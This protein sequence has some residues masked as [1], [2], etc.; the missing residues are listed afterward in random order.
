MCFCVL[1]ICRTH[2]LTYEILKSTAA[3]RL[4]R[5]NVRTQTQCALAYIVVTGHFCLFITHIHTQKLAKVFEKETENQKQK[6]EKMKG[7]ARYRATATAAATAAIVSRWIHFQL[8]CTTFM[9]SLT[10]S[11]IHTQIHVQQPVSMPFWTVVNCNSKNQFEFLVLYCQT[12]NT[13]YSTI[14]FRTTDNVHAINIPKSNQTDS[15]GSTTGR[16]RRERIFTSWSNRRR[17]PRTIYSIDRASLK[18]F[19]L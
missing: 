6:N 18:C 10:Q 9:Q 2:S 11:H 5:T 12:I 4:E 3:Q 1:Y 7:K 13:F 14:P 15:V 17:R 16:H 19:N 8:D